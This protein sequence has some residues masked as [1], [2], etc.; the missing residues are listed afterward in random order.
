MVTIFG[1]EGWSKTS[2]WI[3]L[4]SGCCLERQSNRPFD[5]FCF[6]CPLISESKKGKIRFHDRK[7]SCSQT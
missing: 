1:M 4:P 7:N 3:S 5:F 2:P 6:S